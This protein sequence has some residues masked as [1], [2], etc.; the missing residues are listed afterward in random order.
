M[1]PSELEYTITVPVCRVAPEVFVVLVVKP[2]VFAQAVA[3]T[4]GAPPPFGV[5][6]TKLPTLVPELVHGALAG[7]G[8]SKVQVVAACAENPAPVPIAANAIQRICLFNSYPLMSSLRRPSKPFTSLIR[9][10]QTK[11]DNSL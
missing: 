4:F 8:T 1:L 6:W 7:G 2:A 9:N 5:H 3:T 11:H 10:S